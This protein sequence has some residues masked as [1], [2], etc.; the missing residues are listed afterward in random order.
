VGLLESLAPVIV[1][2]SI[3]WVGLAVAIGLLAERRGWRGLPWFA[4]AVFTT[5]VVAMILMLLL[6]PNER[7]GGRA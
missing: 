7:P 2:G 6:T 4:L 1:I 5:P 3:V